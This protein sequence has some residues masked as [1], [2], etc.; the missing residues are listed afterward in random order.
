MSDTGSTLWSQPVPP[1]RRMLALTAGSDQEW[2][3][4]LLPFDLHGS[5]GHVEALRANQIVS[6]EEAR[7]LRQALELALQLHGRGQSVLTPQDEDCHTAIERFVTHQLGALGGKLQTARSR[8]DQ[9]AT[10]LRLFLRSKLESTRRL[11][12]G[13][14]SALEQ[15]AQQFGDV[16]WPGYTHT[17]RAMPSNIGLWASAFSQ[18][19]RDTLDTLPA[20]TRQIERCPLGSASGYGLP[21]PYRREPAA[22]VLGFASVQTPVSL[23]QNERGKLEAAVLFWCCQLAYDGGKL[24]SDVVLFSGQEFGYLTLS[25]ELVTG[26]SLMPHKRNPDLFEL[27]R[28]RA[29]AIDGDLLQVLQL[30]GK[31]TSGYHR[32][33]QLLKEPLMRGLL[34]TDELLESLALGVKGLTPDVERCRDAI[35]AGVLSTARAL[36]WSRAGMPFREAHRRAAEELLP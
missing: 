29:A 12:E 2:D 6:D 1:N 34:R 23:V 9:V 7:Q 4:I 32:D 8:N 24:A 13:L 16:A 3:R 27:S 17:R 11:A 18:G 14:V 21:F 31:L 35:D 19:I 26:S 25:A 36:E 28:A 22:Q 15:F 30:R 20:L 33:F 5:I 10:A